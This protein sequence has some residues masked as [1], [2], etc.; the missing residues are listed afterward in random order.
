MFNLLDLKKSLVIIDAMGCQKSIAEKIQK[1]GGDYLFAV[2]GNQGRINKTFEKK[3][4]PIHFI[5]H[6]LL[7]MLF[8]I[9][10]IKNNIF[11]WELCQKN[12]DCVDFYATAMAS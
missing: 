4:P 10:N 3:F 7:P 9:I 2:K 12:Y 5:F 1:Q 11:V 8:P 6:F